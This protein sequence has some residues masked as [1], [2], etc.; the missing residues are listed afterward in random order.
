M[1]A[2]LRYALLH[3]SLFLVLIE[4][5]FAVQAQQCVEVFSSDMPLSVAR[6]KAEL[7]SLN[8][9]AYT[10]QNWIRLDTD[11]NI[12]EV[13]VI[14]L[15]D[16]SAVVKFGERVH[17]FEPL[18]Y[19]LAQLLNINVPLTIP[20]QMG[21]ELGMA[22]VFLKGSPSLLAHSSTIEPNLAIQLFDRLTLQADR[23]ANNILID[24]NLNI[25][26]QDQQIA[27]DHELMFHP[28][29]IQSRSYMSEGP[30]A[31]L[32]SHLQSLRRD[33]PEVDQAFTDPAVVF[34]V[35][36]K[37]RQYPEISSKQI[38]YVENFFRVYKN[39]SQLYD[40]PNTK[41]TPIAKDS[42]DSRTSYSFWKRLVKTLKSKGQR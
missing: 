7:E 32:L 5:P 26:R 37:L 31:F 24:G 35:L 25:R 36:K 42:K 39:I 29:S 22:Q 17:V 38:Q 4:L 21:Q 30:N 9:R 18:A 41:I 14:K 15:E 23:N 16:I 12:H 33:F 20:I 2:F 34:K 13:Y 11:A 19:E 28:F 10:P 27:I 8:G 40:N 6:Q 1:N 3:L